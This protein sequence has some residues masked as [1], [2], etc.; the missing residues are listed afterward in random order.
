MRTART[1]GKDG[2]L[3]C[4]RCDTK[5][6]VSEFAKDSKTPT[7]HNYHCKVCH[8]AMVKAHYEKNK[9]AILDKR[10]G[11][12]EENRTLLRERDKDYYQRTKGKKP[13]YR[14]EVGTAN[15]TVQTAVAQNRLPHIR[16]MYCYR[17]HRTAK[18]YHH[19]SYLESDRLC[20]VPVCR[21]C[22][23]PLNRLRP[24]G[25]N[26]MGFFASHYGLIRIAIAT[27]NQ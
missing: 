7:G 11:Y 14:H 13:R 4:K 15:R 12:R 16:T 8:N 27:T 22:H 10:V 25:G 21:S 24:N 23:H 17:C 5:K 20:V 3:H 18:D 9:A 19:Q 2:T 26:D 1:I 6:P